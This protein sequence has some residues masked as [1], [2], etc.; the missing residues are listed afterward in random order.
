ME[1]ASKALI[2]AG[3]ILLVMLILT[4][5]VSL[6]GNIQEFADSYNTELSRKELIKYNS[7]YEVFIGRN[8]I[9]A[10][11]IVTLINLAQQ[12]NEGTVITIEGEPN[13]MDENWDKND[14]MEKNILTYNTDGT[15]QSLFSYE[16]DSIQYNQEGKVTK[17]S[18]KKN[19]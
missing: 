8:D 15:A 12:K 14:F 18:F 1:N 5:G 2:I 10:Q 13:C 6:V 3:G 17:I 7:S 19:R 4:I 11:E 9:T 16:S